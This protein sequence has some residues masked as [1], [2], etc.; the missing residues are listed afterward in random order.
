[1]QK[2]IEPIVYR[3]MTAK[4]VAEAYDDTISIPNLAILLQENRE[5]AKICKDKLNPIND[6]AYGSEPIQKLDIYAPNQEKNI[7]VLLDIHGGGWIY[8][9]K[10]PRSIPAEA[11]MSQ[12]VIWV[13]IDYGLFPKY[14]MEE[15]ISHIRSAVAWIYKNINQYGGNPNQLYISGQSSG[16]HLAATTLMEGWHNDFDVPEGVIKGLIALSGVYDLE[17]LVYASK[18]EIQEM[19]RLTLEEAR[20]VSPFY[21]LPK[22]VIPVIIAYGDKEPL[23]YVREA[24][25][26]TKAL[27]AVGCNVTLIKVRNANHF[28]MINAF[29]NHDESLFK[30]T[31]KMILNN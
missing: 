31:M 15:I 9:S 11:I 23:A 30:T 27:E 26:Y 1:M 14:R 3:G 25:D 29:S 16:A 8:G 2:L 12:R 18:N 21:H 4:Q 20:C 7:P 5:R 22:K 13:T 28:D 17:G 24:E 10:N 6:V 19:L